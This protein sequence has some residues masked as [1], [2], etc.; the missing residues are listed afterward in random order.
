MLRGFSKPKAAF[1]DI[2]LESTRIFMRPPS[3]QDW[4]IWAELRSVNQARIQP[5]EPQWPNEPFSQELFKK[6]LAR[7][8][9]EW[10]LGHANTFLIFKK[11]SAQLIG[12]MN[13]NNICR[14]AAQ[15][16]SLGYWI[17]QAHEG[18]GYMAESIKLTLRHCFETLGLHRVNAACL[19]H[20]ERSKRT[21]LKAGFKE[22]GFAEKYIQINGAWQDH[23]LFGLPI[24]NW[25]DYHS[26]N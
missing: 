23:V 20:N 1:P 5:F 15:Y 17:D 6:R 18:H 25:L 26:S 16:A 24:E 14:G 9:R 10:T 11:G 21:L 2:T 22:E 3:L 7:Q 12:G 8:S 13:I 19:T 4:K